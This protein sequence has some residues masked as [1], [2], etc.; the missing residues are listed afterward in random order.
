MHPR[1]FGPFRPRLREHLVHGVEEFTTCMGWAG[2]FDDPYKAGL[3]KV[4][5]DLGRELGEACER[6]GHRE[7][8]ADLDLPPHPLVRAD[9]ERCRREG[10]AH[11]LRSD[12]EGIVPTPAEWAEKLAEGGDPSAREHVERV[13]MHML[14][15]MSMTST[16][17]MMMLTMTMSMSTA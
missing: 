6:E 10:R 11:K 5:E 16:M 1:I 12:I 3:L 15:M 17:T 4:L 13:F 8:L 7:A 2:V 14:V 9:Q